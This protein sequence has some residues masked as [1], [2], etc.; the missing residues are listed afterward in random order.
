R[1]YLFYFL[2]GGFFGG[3]KNMGDPLAARQ[4]TYLIEDIVSKGY[5]VV[6]V[7]YALVTDYNF[8]TTVIQMN[9]A[10]AYRKE[11]AEEYHLN[12]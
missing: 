12:M 6:N 11:H 1:P 7:D 4:E 9:Q 5:N 10:I 2:G 8:P 3:R